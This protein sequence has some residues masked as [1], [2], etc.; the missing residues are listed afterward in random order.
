MIGVVI[1]S[2]NSADV[3]IDCLE[4]LLV[5][6]DAPARIVVVDNASPEGT[7]EIIMRWARTGARHL[8]EGPA[9]SKLGF[10]LPI[11]DVPAGAGIGDARLAVIRSSV[12]RG[13]AGGVNIGLKALAASPDVE[14]FWVL[15]PDTVVP[16]GVASAYIAAFEDGFDGM[17]GCRVAFSEAPH[18]VQSDGG[19]V[20]AWTGV[21]ANLNRGRGLEEAASV[22]DMRLSFI[23]G[24]NLVVNRRLLDRV[25]PMVESYFL[26][27]EEVDWAFRAR[28]HGFDIKMIPGVLVWHHGGTSIGSAT[29]R[30]RQSPLAAYFNARNRMRFVRSWCPS[31]LG[32]AYLFGLA[33]SAQLA[34]RGEREA[35]WAN[36][37]GLHGW[38]PPAS[39][40]DRITPEARALAFAC[41]R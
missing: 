12:N 22:Q 28:R 33:K 35:A 34:L 17:M 40:R 13:Y 7:A 6:E 3:I 10:P 25:G 9:A 37:A 19:I 29:L 4:S 23:S 16:S 5:A 39:V 11:A 14:L 30:Q 20:N 2:Y 31:R 8:A 15:N 41:S 36:L 26:Y 32:S 38:P 27:Y 21:C 18:A 1:V 24:S